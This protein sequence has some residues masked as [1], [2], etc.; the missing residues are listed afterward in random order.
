MA[1]V[2]FYLLT[3]KAKEQSQVYVSLSIKS[4]S[5]TQRIRFAT[6]E[7]FITAYCNIRKNAEGFKKK[8]DLV[9]RNTVFYFEYDSILRKIRDKLIQIEMDLKKKGSYTLPQIRDEYYK[10]A[11]LIHIDPI[12]METTF[13]EFITATQSSWGEATLTKINTTF[14]HLK[15]F[16]EEFGSIHLETFNTDTLSKIKNDYFVKKM[17]FSNNTSN[18][19]MSIIKQFL[20]YA[21]KKN[22]IPIEV[23]LTEVK[24]LE[25]T[26]P[27]KIAFRLNEVTTLVSLDFSNIIRLDRVRDLLCLE[28]F[29]GQRFGDIE[30]ILNK[31]NLNENAISFYQGKG[32]KRTFIPLHPE[33]TKHL[34]RLLKKYPSGFGEIIS[35]Q[36]FNEYVK[37]ICRIAKFNK[38]HSWITLT[39]T[40]KVEHSDFRYNLVSSHTGRRTFCTLA[41]KAGIDIKT[42]MTVSGHK[43]YDQFMDY[44]KVDDLDMKE[45]FK[46][47]FKSKNKT[48]QK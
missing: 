4:K 38:K 30:K 25:E 23:D 31:N 37:E 2:S 1:N 5:A 26:E 45:D 10:Q 3:P 28:I 39:G 35:N 27:Y 14:Q 9:K 16:E 48:I 32:N 29:T 34:E 17:K 36:K 22:K 33:L 24:S 43:K 40:E 13:R 12:T 42:I 46:D 20:R 18:K 7:C 6:G 19:Y 21:K 44:V 15:D 47:M 8:K 41:L 11:G